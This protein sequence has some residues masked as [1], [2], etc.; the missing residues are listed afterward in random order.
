MKGRIRN[1]FER[2]REL[3]QRVTEG[4]RE[5]LSGEFHKVK[6]F[7]LWIA[8]EI[9]ALFVLAIVG[10]IALASLLQSLAFDLLMPFV[11][12]V[13]PG[14]YW[15]NLRIRVG[16][17]HFNIGNFLGNLVF[18]LLVLCLLLL[19]L[20]LMPRRPDITLPQIIVNCPECGEPLLPGAIECGKCGK[21]LPRPSEE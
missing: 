3:V 9:A 13:S 12:L 16:Q 8:G 17:T 4:S 11:G 15:R 1:L 5:Y 2:I 6:K 18:F 20:R 10:G 19:I 14:G 7:S 21:A